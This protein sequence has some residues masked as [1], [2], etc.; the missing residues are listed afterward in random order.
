[1][2]ILLGLFSS[3]FFD[4]SANDEYDALWKEVVEQERKFPKTA[5]QIVEKIYRKSITDNRDDQLIKAIIYRS[6]LS[7]LIKD[8]DPAQ[9]ILD[10]EKEMG[11]IKSNAG[12]SIYA[13]LLGQLYHN[14]GIRNA[15][16]FQ[17]RTLQV[18]SDE[19][20]NIDLV[21]SSLESIQRKAAEYYIQS[22]NNSS[23]VALPDLDVLLENAQDEKVYLKATNLDQFLHLRC[24]QHFTQSNAFVG[25]PAGHLKLSGPEYF[26]ESNDAMSNFTPTELNFSDVHKMVLWIFEKT[27]RDTDINQHQEI[28]LETQRIDYVYRNAGFSDKDNAYISAL[29]N[30]IIK[31][32][33]QNGVEYPTLQLVNYYVN[34]S[35]NN[36]NNNKK[37]YWQKAAQL[38]A[39]LKSSSHDSYFDKYIDQAESRIMM[40]E[41]SLEMEQVV[42]PDSPFLSFV[43]YRNTPTLQYTI[44]SLSEEELE[45]LKTNYDHSERLKI[46]S[47]LK[48]VRSGQLDLDQS[49]DYNWHTKEFAMDGLPL[50]TYCI[51]VHNN[52]SGD[53]RQADSY[54]MSIFHVSNLA[55]VSLDNIDAS[56]IFIL[57]R[58]TGV[59]LAN[60]KAEVFEQEYQS[61]NRKREWVL[62]KTLMS[63]IDGRV[64]FDGESRNFTFK[65]VNGD[66][67]LDLR[68]YHHINRGRGSRNHTQISLFTDRAIYRPG[69]SVYFKG[70]LTTYSDN[71]VPSIST[72]QQVKLIW[73]DAN[74]QVISEQQLN[75]DDYGAFDGVLK[76]PSNGLNG[77]YQVQLATNEGRSSH[78]IRVEEY[79]R[80][81]L[82]AKMDTL[83]TSP[84]LGDT[85]KFYGKVQSYSGS[86]IQNAKVSYRVERKEFAWFYRSSYHIHQRNPAEQVIYGS[87]ETN[88]HGQFSFDIPTKTAGNDYL[89]YN[90]IAHLDITDETGETVTTTKSINLG[91]TPFY[92]NIEMEEARFTGENST[93]TLNSKN[94]DGAALHTDVTIIAS[95]IDYPQYVKRKKKWDAAE[96][97]NL[98][99]LS[100]SKMFPLDVYGAESNPDQWPMLDNILTVKKTGHDISLNE[101][102]SLGHGVYRLDFIARDNEGNEAK[103]TRYLQIT[104]RIRTALGTKQLWVSSPKESYQPGDKVSLDVTSPYKGARVIYRIHYNRTTNK[105]E[106]MTLN[107]SGRIEYEIN[108]KD[109]GGFSI[110]LALVKN[111]RFYTHKVD[112][113]IP[114]KEKELSIEYVT[115]RD[116]IEPGSRE[117]WKIKIN[118][119]QGKSVTGKLTAAMYDA[120]LDQFVNHS[121]QKMF[122]PIYRGY[123]SWRGIGFAKGHA[124]NYI[125]HVGVTPF[126][127]HGY[128]PMLNTFGLLG[129]GTSNFSGYG[130]FPEGAVFDKAVPRAAKMASDD[131]VESRQASLESVQ[132]DTSNDVDL[133]S[134]NSDNKSTDDF[135]VRENLNETVFFIPDL[136]IE[137]GTVDLDFTMNEALTKWNLLLFAY[138]KDL[139]YTFDSK[140]VVTQKKLMV[141]P[142]LP[143]FIRQG[144]KLELTAKVTN[145]TD[146]SISTNSRIEI[147]DA[148]SGVSVASDLVQS[149]IDISTEVGAG[150]SK[151]VI[152]S[153]VVPEEFNSPVIIRVLVS[154]GNHTDGEQSIMPVVS[155][156]ILITESQPFHVVSGQSKD[157]VVESLAKL[158]ESNSI[159][160]HNYTIELTTNPAWLVVKSI[161]YLLSQDMPSSESRFNALYATALMKHLIQKEPDIK[162]MLE[163]WQGTK[164]QS[165]LMQNQDLKLDDLNETPWVKEALD[166]E[167]MMSLLSIYLDENYVTNKISES[168]RALNKYKLSNGGYAWMPGGRDNWYNTQNILEGIG[169]LS[170]LGV[171][172]DYAALSVE[173]S[174]EYLDNRF[175]DHQKRIR[176]DDNQISP[177]VMHYLYVRS[178]F[179]NVKS[180]TQVKQ[181][182]KKIFEK[183]E[184]SWYNY[185]TYSQGLIAYSALRSD[186]ADIVSNVKKSL[187]EKL[188]RNENVGYYWNDLAGYYWYNSDISKQALM[189]ELF[190]DLAVDPKLVSKLKLWL[191]KNKQT[192]NW[193]TQSG[194][195][196][197]CYAFLLG[198]E[199]M[200][201]SNDGIEI[202]LPKLSESIK[203]NIQEL[204]IGYIRK[205]FDRKD[206]SLAMNE[207]TVKNPSNTDVWGAAYWQ[208]Y[209]DISSVKAKVDSPLAL[210]KSVYKVI[211]T[212]HG[213]QLSKID[214]EQTLSP[215]DLIRVK[216]TI[217]LDRPMEFVELKDWR[218]SGLGPVNTLSRYKRQDGLGYYETNKD[219][220]TIFYFSRLPK[221]NW[222]LE[223]DLRVTHKGDFVNGLAQIQ[224][225]YAPEFGS[226]SSGTQLSIK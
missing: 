165:A 79:K 8:E 41:Y 139:A 159:E 113:N 74:R 212:D 42:L 88:H 86:N 38:L 76:I 157:I 28:W 126:H 178:F 14:Y 133:S 210:S 206:I 147:F 19:K 94:A 32:R 156:R 7:R 198:E 57:D 115:F 18:D 192:N 70:L 25:L 142:F 118:D 84:I 69:Q 3:T 222:V 89:R 190:Q 93:I 204:R 109:L 56:E 193:S 6:K 223:Y 146:N 185:S 62:R 90:Y 120:S 135:S 1:M 216:L 199:A 134:N 161:P 108:N 194:T 202:I 122:F 183:I 110:D 208:Y 162:Q 34:H 131:S 43:R 105:T 136:E 123:H 80:P 68:E 200:L 71:Q 155:N 60:V 141:E 53:I 203:P 195:S 50:G 36:T 144:D 95:T 100:F 49:E 168:L 127:V 112:I 35:A 4:H 10:M 67:I 104:D 82:L 160:S 220:S 26:A 98:D 148:V 197:A 137:N 66:D 64:K 23:D 97:H 186:R 180:S 119:A 29:Q 174:V 149:S 46:I 40:K 47:K 15:Y 145:L 128:T 171:Q 33:G 24:I 172:L 96:F 179:P 78:S 39:E 207:V 59:A 45:K 55:Y 116:K 83:D 151:T 209:E 196:K 17:S 215:G 13:S 73:K 182:T 219:L 164:L 173:K 77:Q 225:V 167:E 37:N 22:L 107:P 163:Q 102:E 201:K 130:G 16:R 117:N 92:I 214:S 181:E 52:L 158:E 103:A 153:V 189:I 65:I 213:E 205:D 187:L 87:T 138:D 152:W 12:K 44:H 81:K 91:S 125:P 154:G 20:V 63:D 221:G 140:S 31:N 21:F 170:K 226:Y 75:S 101:F 11:A 191:L 143:R 106:W 124:Y 99:S 188:I 85:I 150:K 217:S 166:E 2:I 9:E 121:W 30:L 5:I 176:L 175:L 177:I 114:W 169:H 54:S 72:N 58:T 111:N 132:A 27:K 211:P 48:E 218:G 224:S 51:L 129:R 184:D 61:R